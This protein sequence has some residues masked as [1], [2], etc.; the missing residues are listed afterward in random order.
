V[1]DSHD[2]LEVQ[3]QDRPHV[4]GESFSVADITARV[5]IDFATKA[6]GMPI[7]QDA[8]AI[9]RWYESLSRRSSMEA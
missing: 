9:A 5:T 1:A 7:S 8:R 3:L 4:A 2:D 6:L